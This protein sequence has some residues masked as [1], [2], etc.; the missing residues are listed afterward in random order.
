VL[1]RIDGVPLWRFARSDPRDR[2][3][4]GMEFQALVAS[5]LEGLRVPVLN[6]VCGG[7]TVRL[8]PRRWC[9][10]AAAAG[11]PVR[12]TAVTVGRR[13]AVGPER[14]AAG[15]EHV[16]GSV[17]VTGD[18][19]HGA[20]AAAL[21][22]A[23]VALAALAGRPLI[24]CTFATDGAGPVLADVEDPPALHDD[25]AVAAVVDHVHRLVDARAV[26]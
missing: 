20:L 2:D 14:R 22:A 17:L 23:C 1:N 8:P 4:A 10:L 12:P 24:R 19:A 11:L 5:W 9:A 21:G 26:A 3:Y 25:H 13:V 16:A 18:R 7:G 6:P 15:A